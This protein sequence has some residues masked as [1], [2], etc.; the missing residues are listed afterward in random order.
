M[1]I[2]CA[3]R[4]GPE[5]WEQVG[6]ALAVSALDMQSSSSPNQSPNA[7]SSQSQNPWSRLPLSEL[8]SLEGAREA[9]R[10]FV[11]DGRGL[12]LP[13]RA[14]IAA[15]LRKPIVAANANATATAA[16][17][18]STSMPHQTPLQQ[19]LAKQNNNNNS[20][21]ARAARKKPDPVASR[22]GASNKAQRTSLKPIV[23]NAAAAGPAHSPT[24]AIATP[25]PSNA[26]LMSVDRYTLP[27]SS[28]LTNALPVSVALS[29]SE[30][31]TP[32]GTRLLQPPP[33]SS[34]TSRQLQQRRSLP[35]R[36]HQRIDE[37]VS[38]LLTRKLSTSAC[39]QTLRVPVIAPI[40]SAPD[41]VYRMRTSVQKLTPVTT[42][43]SSGGVS[44]RSSVLLNLGVEKQR[45]APRY[46]T[47]PCE[48][49]VAIAPEE[50]SSAAAARP[51]NPNPKTVTFQV[52]NEEAMQTHQPPQPATSARV[53]RSD[54]ELLLAP[55]PPSGASLT[56]SSFRA[57][58]SRSALLSSLSSSATKRSER[59]VAAWLS[60][61]NL[62]ELEREQSSS[63]GVQRST[64]QQQAGGGASLRML[65][66]LLEQHPPAQLPH[67]QPLAAVGGAPPS[68]ST[69]GA[70]ELSQRPS[71]SIAFDA[72]AP[73]SDTSTIQSLLYYY[74][75]GAGAMQLQARLQSSGAGSANNGSA[76]R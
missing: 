72:L 14:V 5:H 16:L 40:A 24:P 56:A 15:L 38:S 62:V 52:P 71:R 47:A 30:L 35:A 36:L 28:I 31:I 44:S 61:T 18:L 19:L 7:T 42:A 51:L 11:R 45:L 48:E 75:A 29:T 64:R 22:K 32:Y 26:R 2:G 10:A 9:M 59:A 67:P 70:H 27:A 63:V 25:A 58:L 33:L 21:A 74:P 65:C 54:T 46:N 4:Y 39:R 55:R 49:T 13:S 37:R 12:G 43:S 6:A 57:S 73:P 69:D 50:R 68:T 66:D 20:A 23:R 53:T 60:D 41:A 76:P 17:V 3:R 1:L 8:Q 34:S